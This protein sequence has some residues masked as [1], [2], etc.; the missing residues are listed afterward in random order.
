MGAEMTIDPEAQT[1]GR[2]T[3][4]ECPVVKETEE[5]V[6][7]ARDLSN[8]LKRLARL[9]RNCQSCPAAGSGEAQYNCPVL[10][11]INA[12]IELAILDLNRE[13]GMLP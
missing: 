13:W 7:T 5:A 9:M 10:M 8:S 1:V 4:A 12:Q 2:W 3:P 11:E 6:K